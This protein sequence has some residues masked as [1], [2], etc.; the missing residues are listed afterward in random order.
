MFYG[1]DEGMFDLLWIRLGLFDGV[2]HRDRR[3]RA[4]RNGAGA[5]P[6]PAITQ[7]SGRRR[8]CHSSA[9]AH[10]SPH[11]AT[12]CNTCSD[13]DLR[14]RQDLVSC[15]LLFSKGF[16]QPKTLS[17]QG[18]VIGRA[19]GHPDDTMILIESTPGGG[20][21]LLICESEKRAGI[22]RLSAILTRYRK[23]QD[24]IDTDDKSS[25]ECVRESI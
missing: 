14:A 5:L 8:T 21:C 3:T 15:N 25:D 11:R 19:P 9:R 13:V 2:G 24:H 22:S 1:R 6:G 7:G 17:R 4:R 10:R 12:S 18:R 20:R 16:K 23:P